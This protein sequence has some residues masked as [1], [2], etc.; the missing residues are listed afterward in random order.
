L[1]E[2]Q[3]MPDKRNDEVR[4]HSGRRTRRRR[5]R[6]DDRWSVAKNPVRY[7]HAVLIALKNLL[8]RGI[9]GCPHK[10]KLT[11]LYSVL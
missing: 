11:F 4:A 7:E 3:E 1:R 9:I 10:S 6:R 8:D 5:Y 2:S